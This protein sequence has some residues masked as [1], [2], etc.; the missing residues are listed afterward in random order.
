MTW[1]LILSSSPSPAAP[2]RISVIF[3]KVEEISSFGYS[4]NLSWRFLILLLLEKW[5]VKGRTM[6]IVCKMNKPYLF[7]KSAILIKFDLPFK[8]FE[9]EIR[10]EHYDYKKDRTEY[11]IRKYS[12]KIYFLTLIS[13][14]IFWLTGCHFI[15]KLQNYFPLLTRK[16]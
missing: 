8:I 11:L 1:R 2:A 4:P 7:T 13:F 15:L 10:Y 14:L 6:T 16:K 3:F 9:L 12:W 5:N